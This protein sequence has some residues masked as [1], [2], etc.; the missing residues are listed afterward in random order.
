MTCDE[1]DQELLLLAHGAL[2]LPRRLIAQAHL[3]RCAACRKRYNRLMQV[4][5]ALSAALGTPARIPWSPAWKSAGSRGVTLGGWL[6]AVSSLLLIVLTATLLY[7]AF[8]NP[9]PSCASK[10]PSASPPFVDNCETNL[11]NARRR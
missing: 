6:L 1:R 4:S 5:S 8:S 2:S 3:Q 10:T 7:L 9:A 11:L